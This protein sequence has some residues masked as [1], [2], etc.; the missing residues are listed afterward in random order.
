MKASYLW[1]VHCRVSFNNNS[2][3]E[4]HTVKKKEDSFFGNKTASEEQK[5]PEENS[6]VNQDFLSFAT[7]TVTLESNFDITS[8]NYLCNLQPLSLTEL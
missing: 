4:N 1:V 7:R 5:S 6:Q 2:N 3:N 8:S